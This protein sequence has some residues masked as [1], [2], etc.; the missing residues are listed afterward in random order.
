MVITCIQNA[1]KIDLLTFTVPKLALSFT[2]TYLTIST[3]NMIRTASPLKEPTF[4]HSFK[5][6]RLT[7][8]HLIKAYLCSTNIFVLVSASFQ[9]A[10]FTT[11][12]HLQQ[13]ASRTIPVTIHCSVYHFTSSV[14]TTLQDEYQWKQA[15][16]RPSYLQSNAFHKCF[17]N[18]MTMHMRVREAG[19]KSGGQQ[20]KCGVNQTNKQTQVLVFVIRDSPT[21]VHHHH[22]HQL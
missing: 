7:H 4:S 2:N 18:R 13:T 3:T 15:Q 22:H 19:T 10:I 21:A 9:Y 1:C 5:T 14:L 11:S 17:M 6:R 16:S 12:P 20:P 8:N